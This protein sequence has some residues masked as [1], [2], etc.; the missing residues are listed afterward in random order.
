MLN[1]LPHLWDELTPYLRR[2]GPLLHTDLHEQALKRAIL[3]RKG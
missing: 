1:D 3:H 2:A